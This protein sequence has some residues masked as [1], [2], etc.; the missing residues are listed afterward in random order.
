[1]N[2]VE[3]QRFAG[4]QDTQWTTMD[5]QG[6]SVIIGTIQ[7]TLGSSLDKKQHF[8]SVRDTFRPF[9][10]DIS[11]NTHS[12]TLH[13]KLLERNMDMRRRTT[14]TEKRRMEGNRRRFSQWNNIR[15][16]KTRTNYCVK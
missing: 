5:Y 8:E 13:E 9:W 15:K 6:R 3:Q 4:K 7:A 2:Q 12:E 16:T 11:S 14:E 1:M 10:I